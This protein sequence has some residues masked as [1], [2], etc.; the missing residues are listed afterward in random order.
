MPYKL[1]MRREARPRTGASKLGA[2]GGPGSSSKEEAQGD[3]NRRRRL[4]AKTDSK[5]QVD[6]G[7][8]TRWLGTAADG[9]NIQGVTRKRP[10]GEVT[11]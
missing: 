9:E 3:K 2:T 8:Q 11:W 10:E 6:V 5:S 7:A 4:K 1:K